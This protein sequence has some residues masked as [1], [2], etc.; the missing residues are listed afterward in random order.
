MLVE[1]QRG[2]QRLLAGARRYGAVVMGLVGVLVGVAGCSE[3]EEGPEGSRR[4]DEMSDVGDCLGPDPDRQGGYVQRD[5]DGHDATGEIIERV[6]GFARPPFCP[7]G[8]DELVDAE[9]GMVV[10][11]DIASLPQVWCLR[12]LEPPHPGDPGMGGG[13]LL[14]QDCIDDAVGRVREVSCDGTGGVPPRYRVLAVIT[15][16]EGA[17]PPET[18]ERIDATIDLSTVR[19]C[20]GSV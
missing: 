4:V 2:K 20:A 11:G 5:C 1:M 3:V 9:Q 19:Y 8:T 15:T 12:N 13:E 7:P 16:I 10:N 14:E 17:C 18:I 6:V